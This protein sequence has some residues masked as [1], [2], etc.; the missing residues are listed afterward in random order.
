MSDQE[1]DDLVR[2][3]RVLRIQTIVL[4]IAFIFG[5]VC[6]FVPG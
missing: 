4:F 6:L 2:L 1:F 5:V 3:V